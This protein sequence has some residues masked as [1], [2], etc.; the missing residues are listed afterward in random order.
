M[1]HQFVKA[2]AVSPEL[3]VADPKFNA[4]KIIEVIKAQEEKG[5]WATAWWA[6]RRA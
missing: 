6:R 2:A 1:K 5:T 3:R 4:E